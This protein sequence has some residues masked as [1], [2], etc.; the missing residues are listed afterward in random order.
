MSGLTLALIARIPAAGVASF[1][2]Y[3]DRVLPLLAAHGGTLERRLA[4]VDGT[5]EIHIVRFPERVGLEQFRA[6]PRRAETA[7]LLAQ[8]GAITE[9]IEVA[10]VAMPGRGDR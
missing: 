6:D 2:A 7:P 9:L 3:E 4:N 5:L 10:D 8:S 1:R